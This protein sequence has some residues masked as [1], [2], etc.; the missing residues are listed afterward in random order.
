MNSEGSG[1]RAITQEISGANHAEFS[2]DGRGIII[3]E[4]GL[5]ATCLIAGGPTHIAV[6]NADGSHQRLLTDGRDLYDSEPSFSP[7]GKTI[8]FTRRIAHDLAQTMLVMNADGSDQRPLTSDT[9]AREG[10]ARF[11]PDGRT[12]VYRSNRTGRSQIWLT[13]AD[14]SQ[15]RRL[16][17]DRGSDN[18]PF[19]SPDGRQIVFESDRSGTFQIWVTNAD[20]TDQHQLTRHLGDC[21]EPQW[22][23]Q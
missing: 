23:P 10:Q 18:E 1:Q 12:I 14:G 3:S 20:G 11:S 22:G 9:S 16:T 8:V 17:F 2:P 7:N 15:Q 19:F 5:T 4:R 6:M 13:N 21:S